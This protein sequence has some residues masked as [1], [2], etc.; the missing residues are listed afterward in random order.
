MEWGDPG[1]IE[2]QDLPHCFDWGI[3]QGRSVFKKGPRYS[4]FDG[5]VGGW[6]ERG[7]HKKKGSGCR[8]RKGRLSLGFVPLSP[9]RPPEAPRKEDFKVSRTVPLFRSRRHNLASHGG[10]PKSGNRLFY[11]CHWSGWLLV[12]EDGTWGGRGKREERRIGVASNLDG[13]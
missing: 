6:E 4:R 9:S 2:T 3:R 8:L 1:G 7:C 10:V 12:W 13:N 11:L 5:R